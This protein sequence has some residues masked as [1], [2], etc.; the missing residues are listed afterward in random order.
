MKKKLIMLCA[1]VIMMGLVVAGCGN[2]ADKDEV[3]KIATD[4]FYAPMEFMDKGKIVG[5]DADFIDAVMSEAGLNYQLDNTGWDTMLE[6]VK[7]GDEYDA[8]ISSISITEDRQETYDYSYPYFESTNMILVPEGSPVKNALDLKDL[9]VAVQI[10]T[11]ADVL[12]TEIMGQG[13]TN[14]KRFDSNT[15][16]I[17]ELISNGV[18][19]VVADIAIVREYIKNN[20]DKKFVGLLD[21]TNF[22]AEYYGILLPKGSELKAKLDPAIKAVIENGKYAEIYDKWFGEEPDTS[23]LL[24]QMK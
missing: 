17:Q 6:L 19:A 1:I 23:V 16:A 20:P 14:L 11:T 9:E 24:D 7:Q 12:M 5:F 8:G 4:A 15:L 21:E 10:M 18:D 22:S 2:S 3:Y 13:N